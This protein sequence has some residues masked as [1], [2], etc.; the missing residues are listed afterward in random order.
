MKK[1]IFI[2]LISLLF[3]C[4]TIPILNNIYIPFIVGKIEK[5]DNEFSIYTSS[6][7]SNKIKLAGNHPSII[8]PTGMYNI[9][10]TIILKK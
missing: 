9:G 6:T 1:I 8:L 3:S 5:F 7:M 4:T 10:D 2:I